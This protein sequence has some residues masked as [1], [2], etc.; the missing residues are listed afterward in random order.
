MTSVLEYIKSLNIE[1]HNFLV[2]QSKFYSVKDILKY[3]STID[4]SLIKKGDVAALIGDFTPRNIFTLLKL[5]D[6]KVVIVPLT[7]DTQA[8]H[9]TYFEEAK[10][11][12]LIDSQGN[13]VRLSDQKSDP[14]INKLREKESSGLVLFS[15]GTTGKPKAILH[16]FENFLNRY[17]TPRP[18]LITLSFL[19]FDHIGGINTILHTIFNKGLIVI[20]RSR[21]VEGIIS[22]IKDYEV[23]LLPTTPTFLRMILMSGEINLLKDTSLK[24][25]SYGTERMDQT[26]LDSLS[27]QLSNVDFRQTYG[28]SELGILRIKSES[29]DS[30]FMSVGGEGVEVKV[31]EK[32]LFIRSSNSMIGYLNAPSPFDEKGWY[33]TKDLVEEKITDKGI[34]YKIIGRD[35]ELIN[36]GGLKFMPADVE[37]VV[38]QFEGIKFCK[39]KSVKNPITGEYPELIY[40]T[41]DD[42]DINILSLKLF[43]KEKLPSYM[44]PRKYIHHTVKIGHRFK[45]L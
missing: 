12:V 14:F 33:N 37:N 13:I 29:R 24:I 2:Y 17:K 34:F 36:V 6:L 30:L 25:I 7:I 20:P 3:D 15:S 8:Q 1:N 16:N 28:M 18:S 43:L 5:I 31:V 39:V 38:L 40:Q 9:S 22:D 41:K 26:T 27:N 11:N 21:T 32:K 10:V 42:E 44:L 4:F 45:K 35:S 19:M 23:E